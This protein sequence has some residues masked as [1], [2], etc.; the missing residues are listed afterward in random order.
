MTAWARLTW[1]A[2]FPEGRA[3]ELARW[4]DVNAA[5]GGLVP[6]AWLLD[7]GS[8]ILEV[9]PWVREGPADSPTSWGR[10]VLEPV[11]G[12]DVAA[13]ADP[14]GLPPH[15]GALRLA[16]IGW[17]TVDADRAEGDL[18][19]WLGPR[20]PGAT[21]DDPD[22]GARARLRGAGSLPGDRIVILEPSTEGRAAASLARDGEG[23]CA[24]YLRAPA[25]IE[26]W[27]AQAAERGARTRGAPRP[28]PFGRQVALSGPPPAGPHIIVVERV[29]P[30]SAD[31]RA[32]TIGA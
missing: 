4:L 26:A 19:P 13:P 18:D 22:L 15:P 31:P 6:D 3:A 24:V 21:G 25:S 12:G 14:A 7:L 8:A 9:R 17:A 30:P 28:G 10:L 20:E 16:G 29:A 27:I 5:P 32:S 23:P 2:A 11:P 1:Q